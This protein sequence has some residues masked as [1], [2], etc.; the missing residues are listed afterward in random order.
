M[1]LT[2]VSNWEITSKKNLIYNNNKIDC[3]VKQN[4]RQMN[5]MPSNNKNCYKY[6]FLSI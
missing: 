5:D 3:I 6:I 2:I 1:H 4:N